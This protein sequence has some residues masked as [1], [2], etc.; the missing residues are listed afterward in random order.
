MIYQQPSL[1]REVN[2]VSRK[3]ENKEPNQVCVWAGVGV[4][5]STWEGRKQTNGSFSAEECFN[6]TVSKV[7]DANVQMPNQ[8][9]AAVVW[10]IE[11]TLG[12]K[13][14]PYTGAAVAEHSKKEEERRN[15]QRNTNIN[16]RCCS[17]FRVRVLSAG[18]ID[19]S[20]SRSVGTQTTHEVCLRTTK[21]IKLSLH[22][23]LSQFAHKVRH[24]HK[25]HLS[26]THK[27]THTL[28]YL[29]LFIGSVW[30][31]NKICSI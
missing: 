4:Q 8:I 11:I 18:S 23:H 28:C 27:H 22:A 14:L 31:D 6:I 7:C 19:C 30:I 12:V 10:M 13:G 29:P 9:S 25:V 24:T 3:R 2:K 5:E 26:L 21:S 1:R 20:D 15:Q 17:L 16:P